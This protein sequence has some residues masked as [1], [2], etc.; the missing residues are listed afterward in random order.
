MAINVSPEDAASRWSSGLAGSTAKWQAGVEAVTVS[1]T[2]LA[3]RAA[4]LWARNVAAAKPKFA[5]N[6]AKVTRE[7][8]ISATVNK[9]GPRLASGAQAA[10][11]RMGEVF[12]KLFPYIN[13]VTAS[14]P[15][16]GDLEQN[17]NRMGDFARKMSKFSM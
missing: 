9:G 2:Q 16:R 12:T 1:P 13:Q 11:G 5:A 17:I 15:P 14:L 4:D 6:S 10:Q 3:A 7:Q 8:W